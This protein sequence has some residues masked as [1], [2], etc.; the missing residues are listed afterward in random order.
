MVSD[1]IRLTY[2][3]VGE[4]EVEAVREVLESGMLTQ[5]VVVEQFERLVAARVGTRHA[6]ATS[7]CTTALHLT[8]SA[9]GLSAGDE[10]AISDFTFPATGNVVTQQ[11]ATPV[12]VDVNSP[13]MTM[14]PIDLERKLT[15]RTRAVLVVNAFGVVA[16]LYA[17]KE[18]C[19]PLAIPVIEDAAT[20]MGSTYR[21][22][23]SGGIVDAAC[24]SF[25]PR[26]VLTTGE[27]GMITTSD[28][29]L[30][31]RISL[32][33]SHGGARV[34]DQPGLTFHDFGYNYRLSDIHG[35]LGVIQM[36]RLDDIVTQRRRIA[37][38]MSE[39]LQGLEGALLPNDPDWGTSTYQSYV[40][41]MRDKEWRNPAIK[42]LSDS[43]I[44][45]TLG[46]YALHAQPSFQRLLGV[47]PGDLPG[48]YDVFRRALTLPLYPTMTEADVDR[49]TDS[50]STIVRALERGELGKS[51]T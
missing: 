13:H 46:T 2:P 40:V 3:L 21:G 34:A 1:P 5:G 22:L 49:V 43:G 4:E 44:E 31:E 47:A 23:P 10:V 24:F 50:F 15:N 8:L 35:A 25:H 7:S 11:G 20:S 32:L 42:A 30:A 29:Q 48:S 12:L 16:D 33:R 14:D 28:D 36:G 27:G 38:L 19:E 6:F 45:S 9:L 17:I 39:S 41:L 26:K 18:L 37:G 51:P